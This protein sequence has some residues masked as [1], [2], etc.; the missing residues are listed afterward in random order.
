M[1]KEYDDWNIGQR[2]NT[3][4]PPNFRAASFIYSIC[5]LALVLTSIVNVYS[6]TFVNAVSDNLPTYFYVINYIIYI[7]IGIIVGLIIRLLPYRVLNVICF[8]MSVGSAVYLWLN[9]FKENGL[10]FNEVIYS[11]VFVSNI[12]YLCSFFAKRANKIEKLRELAFPIMLGCATFGAILFNGDLFF[13]VLYLFLVIVS[14][15]RGGMNLKGIGL[16]ILYMVIPLGCWCFTNQANLNSLFRFLSFRSISS[17]SQH[18]LRIKCLRNAGLTGRGLGLGLY[19]NYA[20]EGFAGPYVLCNIVDE[21]GYLGAMIVGLLFLVMSFCA[22]RYS[23]VS[24]STDTYCSNLVGSFSS[25][26]LI[27]LIL[28]VLQTLDLI[29]VNL[30]SMPF[31]S[32]GINVSQMIVVTMLCYKCMH[33]KTKKKASKTQKFAEDVEFG[34]HN[35]EK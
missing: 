7:G 10:D 5:V 13:A 14:F 28:N 29:P 32:Y 8:F 22:Y 3:Q 21:T 11:I 16:L 18:E 17:A 6:L 35:A 26:I 34:D 23:T 24:L 15:R 9:A 31:Y 27:Q 33:P 2:E 1:L 19:K 25:Y 20:I 12:I 4:L 30:I